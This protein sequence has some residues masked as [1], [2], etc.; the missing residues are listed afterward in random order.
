MIW[1]NTCG[2]IVSLVCAYFMIRCFLK[3]TCC[4]PFRMFCG[5]FVTLLRVLWG[6][7]SFVAWGFYVFFRAIIRRY[8]QVQRV[9]LAEPT[10][11]E[12]GPTIEELPD[13]ESEP[14][15]RLDAHPPTPLAIF[16]PAPQTPKPKQQVRPMKKIPPPLPK[17]T[18]IR[19]PGEPSV[20]FRA[21][22]GTIGGGSAS[23]QI[24]PL[25]DESA[26]YD[27]ILTTE[28]RR[29][30]RQGWVN[31]VSRQLEDIIGRDRLPSPSGARIEDL[32]TSPLI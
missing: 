31:A 32:P 16:P 9:N 20:S 17:K 4:K 25:Y 26:Y 10:T 2:L 8:Q 11:T 27:A 18:I 7:V 5:I 12:P 13:V 14:P 30:S 28:G 15:S 19:S 6:I 22:G 29:I 3:A 21:E 23:I 24:E 1:I